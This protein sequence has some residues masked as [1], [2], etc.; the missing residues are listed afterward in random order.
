MEK[1]CRENIRMLRKTAKEEKKDRATARG[2]ES[3]NSGKGCNQD[4]EN[5]ISKTK[6]M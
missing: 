1:G 6:D 3:K 4:T 5:R 2:N